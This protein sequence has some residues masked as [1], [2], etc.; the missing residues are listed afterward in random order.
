MERIA[1]L[2]PLHLVVFPGSFYSLHIFEARYKKMVNHCRDNRLPFVIVPVFS[3]VQASIGTMVRISHISEHH[4]DG[5]FDITIKGEERVEIAREWKHSEGYDEGLI[6]SYADINDTGSL[7]EEGEL[8]R[9]FKKIL[10]KVK[11]TLEDSFWKNLST[12]R[13]KSF[14]VAEKSGLTLDQQIRLLAFREESDRIKFLLLH[15]IDMQKYLTNQDVLKA[16]ILNDGYVN[17]ETGA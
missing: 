14:K 17:P 11:V 10:Q 2:F 9:E 5:S 3:K 6:I 15:F 8:E 4:P 13:S 1:P 7:E 16:M 12:A